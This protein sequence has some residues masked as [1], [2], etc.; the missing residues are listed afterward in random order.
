MSRLY[1]T[2]KVITGKIHWKGM[3]TWL[4][5]GA[6]LVFYACASNSDAR[7]TDAGGTT[8]EAGGQSGEPSGGGQGGT[9]PAVTEQGGT[10]PIV[11]GGTGPIAQ[12]GTTG[13]VQGGSTGTTDSGIGP[14]CGNGIIEQG[15]ECDGANLGGTSCEILQLGAG[16]VTCSTSC[17][18]DTTM[19]DTGTSTGGYGG[20]TGGTGATGGTPQTDNG[21]SSDHCLAGITTYNNNGPFTYR[22]A[23]AGAINMWIPDV[24]AGCKVPM[25]HYSNGTGAT[26]LFYT[27]ILSRLASNG[28]ITLCYENMNTGAGTFGIEAYKAALAQYP[29]MADYRFGSTGHSQGGMAAF[30]TLAYAEREWGDQG[31]Y[32]A[33][34]MEP[35]S[36]FGANPIEG[37]PALYRSITSP[38]FMFSGLGTDTLVSQGWVQLAFGT[39]SPTTEAYFYAK[40]GANHIAT[41]GIDGA[42]VAVPWFRW[43]L[44]GDQQACEY[45]KAI[46]NTNPAWSLVASQNE[47]PCN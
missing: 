39:L 2:Q 16:T 31:I 44:L 22:S 17:S 14:V 35:A 23:R 43:K 37:Y 26:C 40:A 13:T 25:V 12:G 20:G 34:P 10:G 9:T 29:D 8:P 5:V 11:Q 18:L 38:V 32:A 42:E 28:F 24:P 3:L 6:P 41:I 30:N 7:F 15:E 19:C 27:A 4:A 36:G 33:L 21:V 1:N 47:Q 45:F 46:P